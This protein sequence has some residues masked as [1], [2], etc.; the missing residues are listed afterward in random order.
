MNRKL[1]DIAAAAGIRRIHVL[2]WRD[3]DDVEAGGS[4]RHLARVAELWAAAGLDVRIRT[5][6]AQGHP[7][8][9]ER[10]GYAADRR[11]G[12]YLIF[13]RA[14]LSELVGRAGHHDAVV[15]VWNGMPFFTPLWAGHPRLAIVHHS[16]AD[17]WR[18]ALPPRLATLGETIELRVAPPLYRSTPVVTD[19]ESAR[20]ELVERLGLRA[21][22]VSVVPPGVDDRFRPGGTRSPTPL[23]C[24]VGRLI[25][26]KRHH[27]LVRALAAVK[28]DV[29]ELEAVIAGDGFERGHLREVVRD[30]EAEDWIH[31]P[32]RLDDD[33]VVALFQRAW[34]HASASACEGWGMTITESAACETP[35]VVT[36]ATGHVDAVVDGET[37][38]VADGASGLTEG[39]RRVLTDD[40]LRARLGSQ[41]AARARRFTWEQTARGILGALADDA[42]R[43][44]RR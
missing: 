35:S 11:G 30:L 16:Y 15:E 10:N 1:G 17:V 32:G 8:L 42:E 2:S 33:E 26:V 38:I 37:G 34:V 44:R 18:L 24:A 41:A 28:R 22:R 31:L 36:R 3:L 29:P 39:L 27:R 23:V 6:L 40:G 9:V 20:D 4:E 13:P 43:R 19:S 25:P 14:A 21:E 12:R 7:A 5:S